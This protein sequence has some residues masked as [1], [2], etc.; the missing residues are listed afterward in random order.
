MAAVIGAW[1]PADVT[2]PARSSVG[3][4]ADG[5]GL[6]RSGQ[7]DHVVA[8]RLQDR[9]RLGA[10]PPVDPWEP[11]RLENGELVDIPPPW[12]PAGKPKY[13]GVIKEAKKWR[14][15]VLAGSGSGGEQVSA[16]SF[17]T[18]Y[19]AARAVIAKSRAMQDRLPWTIPDNV[20][21]L[22][23]WIVLTYTCPICGTV[24][25]TDP[26]EGIRACSL[27]TRECRKA[28]LRPT[29]TTAAVI[30]NAHNGVADK[31]TEV[32]SQLTQER[33]GEARLTRGHRTSKAA[34]LEARCASVVGK[35]VS[36][37]LQT[38]VGGPDATM[39]K[40]RRADLE[41]DLA[42]GLLAIESGTLGP[43]KDDA[44]QRNRCG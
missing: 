13:R 8:H 6:W 35:T 4:A 5:Q 28:N 43:C 34:Y 14:A 30:M 2:Q 10:A 29:P 17:E 15:I 36:E 39:R 32:P 18:E 22:P 42:R 41:Y 44:D 19:E 11:Q 3:L 40:Y 1:N 27:H 33:D 9:I 31:V 37:A 7:P 12:W 16:G 24:M 23:N 25:Q 38:E 20:A 21:T 26:L